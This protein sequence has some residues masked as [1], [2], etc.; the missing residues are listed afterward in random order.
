[1]SR[2]RPVRT[3]GTLARRSAVAGA[4]LALGLTLGATPPVTA[5]P[6]AADERSTSADAE[7]RGGCTTARAPFRP[8][9]AVI[10]GVVG[11]TKVLAR[12]RDRRGAP[13][14]PPLT[15]RGRWQLAW[16]RESG[17]KPASSR[18]VVRMLA[19]TY[20]RSGAYGTALGNRLLQRLR[21]GARI[22]VSGADGRRQCYRVSHRVR[23]RAGASL[24]AFYTSGGPPKLAILVCSGVR[25]GPGDWS[26]RT[27]WFARPLG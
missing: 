1:M 4:L 22:E 12:G 11:P 3:G 6:S 27:I 17:T 24:A 13:L 16:D 5:S 23:A 15:A 25:R 20:P 19:H 21:L 8:T 7:R 18:G 14:P 10:R 9:R 2:G 26:H